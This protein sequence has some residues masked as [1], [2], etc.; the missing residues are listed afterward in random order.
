LVRAGWNPSAG[1]GIK[2]GIRKVKWRMPKPTKSSRLNDVLLL[3]LHGSLNWYVRGTFQ[4]ISTVFQKKPAEVIMTE[5]PRIN[6]TRRYIRQIVP[7]LYGK[8]FGHNHWQVLWDR[9]HEALLD[10]EVVVVIGC[11][12]LDTDFHLQGMIG[13]AISVR[14]RKGNRL[15]AAVIA[16]GSKTRRKWFKLFK[17]SFVAKRGYP[18]FDAFAR[19]HLR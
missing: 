2:G 18:T 15:K 10:A 11:S 3:K 13:H 9:A 1:Y 14:K 7:P 12:L 8:F 19:K 17:G 6:E 5:H 4:T 16:N